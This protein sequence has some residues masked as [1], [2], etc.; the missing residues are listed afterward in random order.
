MH[1]HV[2]VESDPSTIID[3]SSVG[4]H[5]ALLNHSRL[6]ELESTMTEWVNSPIFYECHDRKLAFK[7]LTISLAHTYI[8]GRFTL[9]SY[10]AQIYLSLRQLNPLDDQLGEILKI[11]SSVFQGELFTNNVY[12]KPGDCHAHYYDMKMAY[13]KVAGDINAIKLFEHNAIEYGVNHAFSSSSLWNENMT[14][15][16]NYVEE[17]TNHALPVFLV[18]LISEKAIWEG[19]NIILDQLNEHESFDLFRVF[20][21]RHIELD[22]DEHGP[23]TVLWFNY[24]LDKL[25]PSQREL[26]RAMDV[27]IQFIK[28]RIK[29]YRY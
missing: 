4:V 21:R 20:M 26:D 7:L 13:E 6:E 19:Y 17:I 8:F 1:N 12:N 9:T 18:V 23:S 25:K 10:A 24:Y 28:L 15:Y 27:A 2:L 16:A 29:T 11:N 5:S 3:L 14:V 22:N